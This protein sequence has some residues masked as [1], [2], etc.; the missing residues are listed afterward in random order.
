MSYLCHTGQLSY[1]IIC[2]QFYTWKTLKIFS[3][4]SFSESLENFWK[5]EPYTKFI[6]Q[7]LIAVIWFE[8]CKEISK[9]M[10]RLRFEIKRLKNEIFRNFFATFKSN[11]NSEFLSYELPIGLIFSEIFQTFWI[12][13]NRKY[14]Q[15]FSCIKLSTNGMIR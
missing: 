12:W 15:F 10:Q 13:R 1:H 4:F 6:G 14:F 11:H 3:I 2:A 5:N 8:V 7:K 9:N